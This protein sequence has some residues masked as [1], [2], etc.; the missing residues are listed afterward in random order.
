MTLLEMQKRLLFL[1]LKV[2]ALQRRTDQ[3]QKKITQSS[4][5][6]NQTRPCPAAFRGN[7]MSN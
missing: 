2:A 6:P 7:G 5:K 3:V 1:E 4:C